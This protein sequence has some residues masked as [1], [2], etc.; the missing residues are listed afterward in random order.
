M[1]NLSGERL[2]TNNP[3]RT[4]MDHGIHVAISSDILP[5][6]PM[7]GIYAAV[8]RRGM[9]GRVF[10]PGEAISRVEALKGYTRQG[11]LADP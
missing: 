6:G 5:I 4:P 10:G 9:S 8:T 2:E 3:L 1:A 11:G 7:V